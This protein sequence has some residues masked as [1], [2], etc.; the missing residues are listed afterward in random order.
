MANAL[1]LALDATVPP[2]RALGAVEQ[3]DF[4]FPVGKVAVDVLDEGAER[5]DAGSAADQDQ[6]GI[7]FL[8]LSE[9]CK[10]RTIVDMERPKIE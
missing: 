6:V 10:A 4:A 3:P 1:E 8:F 7:F 9:Q 5:S 2:A